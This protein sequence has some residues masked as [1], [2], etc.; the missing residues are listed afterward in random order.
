M[1]HGRNGLFLSFE[2]LRDAYTSAKV[3]KTTLPFSTYKKIPVNPF[4]PLDPC[5][6][7]Y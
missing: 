1:R 7:Q 2:K 3:L 5:P 4:H 6:I